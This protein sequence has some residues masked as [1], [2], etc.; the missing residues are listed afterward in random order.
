MNEYYLEVW[1][2]LALFTRPEF[3]VKRMSYEVITPSVARALF[4][5]IY[6]RPQMQWEI[7]DVTADQFES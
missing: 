1:G 7:K 4:E 2:D 5:A 6:W 3:K